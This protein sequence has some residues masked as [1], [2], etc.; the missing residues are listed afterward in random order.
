MLTRVNISRV[1]L[2][3]RFRQVIG[4]TPHEYLIQQRVRRAQELL[5]QDPPP[6]LQAIARQSGLPDRRRLNQVFRRV[7]GKTPAVWR[8]WAIK[9]HGKV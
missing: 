5:L 1:T 7:T 4:D 2:E 8:E 6:S 3:R 9:Q